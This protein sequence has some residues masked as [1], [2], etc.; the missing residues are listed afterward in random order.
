MIKNEKQLTKAD[1][2]GIVKK[3]IRIALKPY[4]TKQDVKQ[5]IRTALNE[6]NDR[7]FAVFAT[8]QPLIHR[9]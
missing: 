5:E 3:E 4:A 7:N 6:Q 9:L 2:G 8:K 1:V